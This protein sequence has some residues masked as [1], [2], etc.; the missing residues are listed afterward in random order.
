METMPQRDGKFEECA[1]R[2]QT[3]RRG[4]LRR[5][6][7]EKWGPTSLVSTFLQIL[8]LVVSAGPVSAGRERPHLDV[9]LGFN[10]LRTDQD[11]L[12]RGVSLSWDGGDPYGSLAK[13]VP[14]QAALNALATEYGLNTV[15][16]Y[17][18]GDSSGNTNAPGINAA[19]CDLLVQRTEQA[20]LY[21][22]ITIGCNGENGTIHS[23]PWS[24]D[25][26]R[27]YAPRYKD[28]PHVLYEAHNEPVRF[29]LD[30]W[31]NSDWDKQLLLYNTIRSLAPDTFILLGSFMGFAGD[32]TYGANYLRTRGV[33]WLNAGFAHHGYESRASIE[34]AITRLKANT[35]FPALLC[36]EFWPGDTAGQGYNSMYESHF[37]GWMQFQWLGARTSDLVD[38]RSKITAAGTL[39]TPDSAACNW[40]ARGAVGLPANGSR[41]GIFSR[42]GAKFLGVDPTTGGRIKAD[43]VGY[44]GAQLDSFSIEHAGPRRVRIRSAD[45]R[46]VRSSGP[47]DS[48]SAS[49]LPP[50]VVEEFEWFSLHDGDFALRAY[51]GGGHLVSVNPSTGLLRPDADNSHMAA[52]AFRATTSAGG[53]KPTLSGIPFRT[54]PTA[55]PGTLQA[56]D[57]D[58]GGEGVAYHDNTGANTGGR[59]RT[60]EGIDIESCAEGGFNLGFIETGEWTEYTV[61]VTGPAGEYLL[62]ARVATPNTGGAFRVESNGVDLTGRLAVPNTG[63]WQSWANLTKTVVLGRGVQIIRFVREV[64]ADFNLNWFSFSQ[65]GGVETQLLGGGNGFGVFGSALGFEVVGRNGETFIV[66]ACPDLAVPVW[67]P[68]STNTLVAG[69][70]E[71]RELIATNEPA[72]FYR[73]RRP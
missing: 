71:F 65:S 23:M 32:P 58:R 16:L 60:G 53:L 73:L 28:R 42:G 63:G 27:I 50:G 54:V 33:S 13:Q 4:P 6:A 7:S 17:L 61:E 22:I 64:G 70:H 43:R 19:D 59:Y 3:P 68:V 39:W 14:S 35:S 57:F 66:E 11:T 55:L 72:R 12:L 8:L 45:G 21:L 67:S 30:S 15:H 36:T 24:L 2:V 41:V 48:L 37:N 38:F 29:T 56:E 52:T 49:V 62:A 9:S 34:S 31:R 47:A 26:W 18:E 51:G 1:E 10:V 46:F 40:P 69:R 5:S 25:F 20:G 44:S